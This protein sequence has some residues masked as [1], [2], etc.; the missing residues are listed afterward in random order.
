MQVSKKYQG[1]KCNLCGN[2]VEVQ[3]VGGGELICC[4]QPMELTT[5]KLTPVNLMKAFAGESQA[6]NKYDYFA[7][8]AKKEGFEQIATFF[9]ET[10][11][12]EKEHAKLEFKTYHKLLGEKEI[13]NT[14]ENLQA[15]FEGEFYEH[16]T[17]YPEFAKIADEEG[18]SE[19]AEM[20]R[21]ISEVEVNHEKRY[22]K[23]KDL[24][25]GKKV[26]VSENEIAWLCR[27]CGHIHYGINAPEE[28][29]TCKHPQ[30]YFERLCENY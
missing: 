3:K 12:N 28:C 23:L 1:Y 9:E 29:P 15:A 8:V 4:G 27:N 6:R 24:V 19:I 10:A 26:F 13:G 18:Y 30:A 20:F 7:K 11:L 25:D 22:R 16:E 14:S 21:K 5:I 17:M 2:E